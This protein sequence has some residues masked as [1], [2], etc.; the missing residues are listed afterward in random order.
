VFE[1][2]SVL[3]LQVAGAPCERVPVQADEL[4]RS[5]A[6]TGVAANLQG[7]PDGRFC[8]PRHGG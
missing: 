6:Q 3:L 1:P 5:Y 4:G 2:C 8:G 7:G